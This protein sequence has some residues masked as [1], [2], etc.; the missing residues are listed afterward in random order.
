[1]NIRALALS[2]GA[3]VVFAC[4]TALVPVT[5]A[6][7]DGFSSGIVTHRHR[8]ESASVGEVRPVAAPAIV[9]ADPPLVAADDNTNIGRQTSAL[10]G[11]PGP[12]GPAAPEATGPVRVAPLVGSVT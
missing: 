8:I 5:A 3:C 1:M 2:A 9:S 10:T 7:A 4:L 11:P 12:A 6:A